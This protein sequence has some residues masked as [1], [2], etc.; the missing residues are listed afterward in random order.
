[1]PERTVRFKAE[2]TGIE[3]W[4][5]LLRLWCPAGEAP[6]AEARF[7]TIRI[8]PNPV[9]AEVAAANRV[10]TTCRCNKTWGRGTRMH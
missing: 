3:T 5:G 4:E 2:A 9:W 8:E 7:L 6:Q 1:M 10:Y